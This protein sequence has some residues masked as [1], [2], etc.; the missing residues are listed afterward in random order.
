[1]EL[2]LM[3][4]LSA[5][6][7]I[8]FLLS[9]C[10]STLKSL[11]NP[12][13]ISFEQERKLGLQVDAQ[14]AKERTILQDPEVNFYIQNLGTRLASHSA[15]PYPYPFT[16]RVIK[17]NSLNAF[18]LPG[19]FVYINSG[20]VEKIDNEAQLASVL[21][22]EISHVTFRHAASRISAIQNYNILTTVGV[23]IAGGNVSPDVAQGIRIFGAG[24][25]LAY[26]REQEAQADAEGLKTLY[27]ANYDVHEMM[28]M[29]NKLKTL[30]KGASDLDRI[31]SD[32]PL[33][34][35]RLAATKQAINALPP[36]T[37]PIID[38]KAF[39]QFKKRVLDLTSRT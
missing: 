23:I 17:D 22:H 35:D 14:L 38:T 3:A 9:G 33:T 30:E 5:V 26:S 15:T 16:F 1:M 10:S 39:D 37:N 32:H 6:L 2:H 36:Q 13:S 27:R 25:I 29:L 20:L 11:E 4:R 12:S 19:G 21:T 24:S 31:F 28:A 18:A 8:L 34:D 7:I